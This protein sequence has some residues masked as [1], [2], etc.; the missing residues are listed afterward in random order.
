MLCRA[1]GRCVAFVFSEDHENFRGDEGINVEKLKPDVSSEDLSFLLVLFH[2]L[3]GVEFLLLQDSLLSL[4]VGLLVLEH[5]PLLLQL[6][7]LSLQVPLHLLVASL[8]LG[9][10]VLQLLLLLLDLHLKHLLHLRLHL[11]HLHHVFAAFLLHLSQRT[12][13]ELSFSLGGVD[14][15]AGDGRQLLTAVI[16][17]VDVVGDVLQILHV[18]SDQHVAQHGEV[19][20]FSVLHFSDAPRI[21]PSSDLLPVHLDHHVAADHGQRHLLLNLSD[22]LVVLVVLRVREFIDFDFMLLDLFHD[23]F[24][25]QLALLGGQG[26]GFGDKRDDVDF[27][28]ESLHELDVQRLQTVSRGRY[29]VQ[30]AVHSVVR[31]RSAVHPR[32]G[33]Q[34]ILAFAVDVVDD[35]LPA[36]AVVHG[37][38]EPRRVH[39]GEGQLD[40]ALLDQHFGLFHLHGL[41]DALGRS[42]IILGV[43]VGQE[44]GVDERRFPETRLTDNHER[45]LEA[46]LHRLAV[47]LVGE[48]GESHVALQ[49]PLS[50]AGNRSLWSLDHRA[51]GHHPACDGRSLTDSPGTTKRSEHAA[52]P[53]QNPAERRKKKAAESEWR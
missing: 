23:L 50:D 43:Q 19:A 38:S 27:V 33:V 36:V 8:Q 22:Q 15:V 17:I 48:V 6:F 16:L 10:R 9:L 52:F 4:P 34:E 12:L 30:A 20:V 21:L 1:E 37:V 7:V 31:H 25:E 47:D 46:S 2:R 13:G 11:L 3:G 14:S 26:V 18:G 29:E 35:R 53:A 39:D 45:E 51:A 28:V 40:A 5:S 49:V 44:Q 42:R 24:L 41:L 32:L